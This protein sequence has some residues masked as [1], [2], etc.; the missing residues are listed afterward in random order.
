MRNERVEDIGD[1]VHCWGSL[2]VI[3]R[4]RQTKPQDGIGVI[5]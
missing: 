4:K 3:G 1:E 2:R 5:A